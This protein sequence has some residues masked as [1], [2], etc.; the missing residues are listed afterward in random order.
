MTRRESQKASAVTKSGQTSKR[1]LFA[2]E[3]VEPSKMGKLKIAELVRAPIDDAKKWHS[4]NWKHAWREVRRLQLR[5]AKAVQENRWNKVQ[6]LQYRL[7]HSFYAKALA[8]K[9]VTS[10]KGKKTPGVDGVLW[11]GARDKWQAIFSLQTRGYQPQ[12]LRRIYVPKKNGKKRPLSIPTMGDRA[13]QSL[14]KLALAPV[15]ET[16]ADRNSYGFREG[17]SCADAVQAAFNALA[18]PNSATWVFEADITGCYDNISHQWMLANLPMDKVVL[19][20]WLKVGYVEDGILYPTRKGTPQGGIASPTLANMTLDG[21]EEAI[22]KAVPRRSRVNFVRYADDF[23]VTGKSKRILEENIKPV[24]ESFLAERGLAL[25]QEKT[26]IT[27]IRDGFTFLGQTFRKRGRVLHITPSKEGLRAVMTK[28][29]ELIRKHVSAPMSVL[30]KKLN[31][32]LR[33]WANYHRHVVSSE[34]FGWLDTHVYRQLWK[35]VKRRHQNKSLK[36]LYRKYW[37]ATGKNTVFAVVEKTKHNPKRLYQVVKACAIGI[38]RHRKIKADA[39]PYLP[40][41]AAYFYER[42]KNKASKE[43][44]ALSARALRKKTA[45][46]EVTQ[47]ELPIRGL[48]VD[49]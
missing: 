6:T 11:R 2:R 26:A 47:L 34:A 20:K 4:I 33:G 40:E 31:E 24:I 30:I 3:I 43:L 7:T 36:W 17:R 41:Y 44:G 28:V 39:N 5:I 10:N 22:H 49:A 1:Y 8:V 13:M 19:K 29:S 42:R 9:R 46:Q 12:P 45:A 27:H 23:I 18:K 32:T 21:L 25:S 37:T 15:A 14:F 35:M 48:L 16:T 38:S